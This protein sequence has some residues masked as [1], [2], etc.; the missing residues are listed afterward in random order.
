MRG[1]A[2]GLIGTKC[3]CMVL[4]FEVMNHTDRCEK[5]DKCEN[6]RESRC[7]PSN[8]IDANLNK[9]CEKDKS[10]R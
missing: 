6:P 7:S 4:N 2:V 9:Y 10:W 5:E 3:A 8:K 1:V